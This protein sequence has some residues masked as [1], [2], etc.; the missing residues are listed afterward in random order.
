MSD[1]IRQTMRTGATHYQHAEDERMAIATLSL[2]GRSVLTDEE[3]AGWLAELSSD[4]PPPHL[5][6]REAYNQRLNVKQYLRSLYFQ[7]L[8]KGVA[9]ALLPAIVAAERQA[10]SFIA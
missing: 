10:N 7:A 3:C 9:T 1:V 5:W 8:H 2:F 6:S 4:L